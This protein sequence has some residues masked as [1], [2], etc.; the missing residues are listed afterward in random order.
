[1]AKK[2]KQEDYAKSLEESFARWHYIYQNGGSDP[3]YTD[4]LNLNL[5]RNH[6]ISY[7]R[8]IEETLEQENYP[9]VYFK[10]IPPEIDRDYMAREDEIRTFAK[11]SLNSYH[12]NSDFKYLSKQQIN[13]LCKAVLNETCIINVLNYVYGLER[14]IAE[15]DLV[16]MRRHC[17]PETYLSSFTSC[18]NKLRK[19]KFNQFKS[20]ILS[21]KVD[22]S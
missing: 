16:A 9:E 17:R 4:G 13:A 7:K 15:D 18:A 1:M 11:Y 6:I 5:V 19:I 22:V 3:F 12:N 8:K 20:M 14:A 21:R 10:E 2:S